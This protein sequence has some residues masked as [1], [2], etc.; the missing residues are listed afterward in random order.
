MKSFRKKGEEI[1]YDGRRKL[2]RDTVVGVVTSGYS[3]GI[4]IGGRDGE[5][6]VIFQLLRNCRRFV[7]RRNNGKYVEINDQKVPV[8]G[9][10]VLGTFFWT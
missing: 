3:D 9:K 4:F 2:R 5:E 10:S 1:G 7:F 6:S 8:L